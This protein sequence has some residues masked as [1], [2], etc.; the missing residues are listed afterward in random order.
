MTQVKLVGA[1]QTELNGLW[2]VEFDLVQ[3]GDLVANLTSASLF[4]SDVEALAAG[5]RAVRY[6]TE[7][8]K[9]PNMCEVF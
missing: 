7:T 6:F 3:D 9:F 4:K 5:E 2:N 8:K 1:N